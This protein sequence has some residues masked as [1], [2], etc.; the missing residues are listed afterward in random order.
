MAGS[1]ETN[2]LPEDIHRCQ[3][4]SAA[5]PITGALSRLTDGEA[6]YIEA[7]D[8]MLADLAGGYDLGTH[9]RIEWTRDSLHER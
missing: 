7:R 3:D 8:G 1:S 9:G 6:G 5:T 4:T 2:T